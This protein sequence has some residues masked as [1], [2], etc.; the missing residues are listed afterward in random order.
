MRYSTL[1][2]KID[3]VFDDCAYLQAIVRMPSMFKEA[4]LSCGIQ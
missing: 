1:Y 4:R 3:F 2:Y